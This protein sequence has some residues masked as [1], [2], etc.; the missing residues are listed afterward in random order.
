MDAR[1]LLLVIPEKADPERDAVARVWEEGHGSVLRLGRFWDPPAVDPRQVRV[2]GPDTFCLVL[3][4]KLGLSLLCPPDDVLVSLS[5]RARQ[6]EIAGLTLAEAGRLVWPA[7]VKSAA[8]KILRSARYDSLQALQD[9]ARGLPPDTPL[10]ISEL[11]RWSCEVRCWV[12][13]G[14]VLTSAV[15]EGEADLVAA[16]QFAAE[17]LAERSWPE[18]FV[19]DLGEISGRGWA[20]IEANAAW[21]AGL[22]GCDPE[23]AAQCLAVAT[24]IRSRDASGDRG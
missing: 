23:G 21:G 24:A 12:L 11:V 6:R 22:N 17:V 4:E 9:E 14:Q 7:F 20:V 10:L 1:D 5:W 19:L 3:A 15:Y 16:R 18:S 2:Y 13:R 8:P